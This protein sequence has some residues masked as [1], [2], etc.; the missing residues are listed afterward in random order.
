MN[1]KECIAAD[2]EN[3]FLNVSEF[4]EEH[5][6]NGKKL[7]AVIDEDIM[8]DI[9]SSVN[10]SVNGSNGLTSGRKVIYVSESDFGKPKAGSLLQLDGSTYFVVSASTEAGMQKI[11]VERAAG[12]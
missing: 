10:F 7:N 1:F 4:A 2:N 9:A 12:R 8:G 6:L 11:I 3:V 5:V